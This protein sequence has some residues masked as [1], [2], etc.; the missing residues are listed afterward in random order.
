MRPAHSTQLRHSCLLKSERTFEFN[1]SLSSS[2]GLRDSPIFHLGYPPGPS[3]TC[4]LRLNEGWSTA[5]Q[6]CANRSGPNGFTRVG[7]KCSAPKPV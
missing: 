6:G 5:R 2:S 3:P 1:L 4:L 7:P